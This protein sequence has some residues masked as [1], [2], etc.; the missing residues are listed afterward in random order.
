MADF[1]FQECY[2]DAGRAAVWREILARWKPVKVLE[3]G[4]FEGQASCFLIETIG[5]YADPLIHCIDTWQGGEEHAHIDMNVIE[6]HFHHNVRLANTKIGNRASITIYKGPSEYWLVNLLAN[7]AANSFDLIYIDGSHQAPDVL[8]D[9]VLSYRLCKIGGLMICDDYLW[10]MEGTL[11]HE[12]KI[13]LDAFTNIY[14][15]KISI[16]MAP[17]YQLYICKT[18]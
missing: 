15:D 12:P 1:I 10:R 3:I 18:A 2:F 4:A 8:F 13:S 14:R 7:G 9:I 11:L 6:S 17:L 5:E 16:L